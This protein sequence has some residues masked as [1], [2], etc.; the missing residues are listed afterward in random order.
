MLQLRM[1][2]VAC[3][4]VALVAII[5][6]SAWAQL[7]G[8][9]TINNGAPADYA[10]IGAAFTAL[11]TQGVSGPCVFE[12]FDDGGTYTSTAEYQLL[13]PVVGMS[14]ANLITFRPAAG[15]RPVIQGS[16]ATSPFSGTGT[17]TIGSI[18][19]L[20]IQGLEL[21]GGTTFG[22]Q[23]YNCTDVTFDALIVHDC[24]GAGIFCY[25]NSTMIRPRVTNCFI[26]NCPGNPGSTTGQA[27]LGFRRCNSDAIVAHNTVVRLT[28]GS[29]TIGVICN[30]GGTS[31][32]W[33]TLSNNIFY[34]ASAGT[35]MIGIDAGMLGP[36]TSGDGNC[37]YQ[38]PGVTTFAISTWPTFT[39]WQTAGYDA[40]GITVDPQLASLTAPF[41]LHLQPTSPC[42]ANGITGLGITTDVDLMPRVAPFDTGADEVPSGPPPVVTGVAPDPVDWL[43]TLIVTGT[44]L[45]SAVSVTIGGVAGT[46]TANT[47]T[48]IDV[49]VSDST[50]TGSQTVAVT[51]A[52]GID[53]T[54][55]VTVNGIPPAITSATPDPVAW[56]ATLTINGTAL[57][58]ATGVTIGGTAATITSNTSTQIQVTVADNN[59]TGAQI[60]QVT[61]AQGNDTVVV[62]V[63]PV[64]PTITSVTPNPVQVL[65]T[66]TINGTAFASTT[67][68]TI[69]GTPAAITSTT[70]TQLQVTVAAATPV[71][72]QSVV[73]T[74]AGGT[75]NATVTVQPP[76]PA[77]TSVSPD[78]VDWLATLTITGTDLGSATSVTIGGTAA[79]ITANT[80]TQIDVTVSDATPT[81]S[82]SVVVTTAGGTDNA[83]VTVNGVA[84]TI[85][86]LS[87]DPVDW[88]ATLT[89]AGTALGSATSVTIGGTAAAITSNTASQIQVT[90]ADGTPTGSQAVVVTTALGNDTGNV[91]VNAIAPNV[92]GVTPNPVTWL[93]TLTING[94]ALS[95]AT[96]VTIGGVNAAITSTTSTQLQVTV[97]AT[98]PTGA[99]TVA[100]TTIGGTDNSQTVTVDGVAPSVSGV[101]PDPV[102]IG[103]TLTI[104][105]NTLANAT[106][107]TIGGAAATITGNTV[108][109]IT[110]TVT[111]A[112]PVGPGQT[113]VVTTAFGSDST[114]TVQVSISGPGVGG[115]GS[116]GCC[117]ADAEHDVSAAWLL[118]LMLVVVAIAIRRRFV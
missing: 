90:V 48:Q 51:T 29:A 26:W 109:Q 95:T 42:I 11:E 38:G 102:Q 104:T 53:N 86:N 13:G 30:N 36:L 113:V 55:T 62:N 45:G 21:S 92:T 25:G 68:V 35:P 3:W 117:A 54:Q 27:S 2:T 87:P 116:G 7:S 93:A 56:L 79:T 65:G 58:S 22:I 19:G 4:T 112:T 83:T 17:I 18:T 34:N 98:T 47:A 52:G 57:G 76:G 91:T 50:P 49:T 96:G 110:V 78:P 8:N 115:G 106:A 46:I 100:V 82:Q 72:P 14:V 111:A 15:E 23:Q 67:G 99:Q 69:G 12:V 101:S 88:L 28:G 63:N 103:G 9:Y 74:T 114:Q 33:G 60:V 70:S 66:L 94:T 75:D 37:W 97:D 77:I 5:T 40:G 32:R 43:Q 85:T 108:T 107:V 6:T 24:I 81:G 80:A 71:G 20:T 73:V 44:D 105:G 64:A 16:G 41:N 89:I 61:T 84:P 59:P 1:G 118:G 31:H 10:S 39:D